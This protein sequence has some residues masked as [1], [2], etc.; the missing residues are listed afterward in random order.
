VALLAPTALREA[1]A[2]LLLGLIR[3]DVPARF[4]PDSDATRSTGDF[5]ANACTFARLFS[6][7]PE[8]GRRTSLPPA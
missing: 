8:P 7:L 5:R 2:A 4:M 1:L 6:E 3:R